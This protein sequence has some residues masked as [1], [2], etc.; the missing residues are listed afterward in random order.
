[1]A[2]ICRIPEVVEPRAAVLGPDLLLWRSN[3][4]GMSAA[5]YQLPWHRDE[6]NDVLDFPSPASHCSLQ[7]NLTD[8]SEQNCV[9]VIPGSHRW[10]AAELAWRGF[11]AARTRD[12]GSNTPEYTVSEPVGAVDIPLA[13][14]E[15]YVF[16]PRLLHASMLRP[17]SG[18]ARDHDEDDSTRYSITLRIA[19]VDVTVF[20]EA[21]LGTPTRAACVILAGADAGGRN[22]MAAWAA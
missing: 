9:A 20:P 5:T 21:F 22:R 15:Y 6:Y 10:D 18:T 17:A 19:T 12:G 8:A 4:F 3:I 1:M 11:A 7:I 16:H 13:A 14:G 2:R